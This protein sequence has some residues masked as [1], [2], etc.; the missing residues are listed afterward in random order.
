MFNREIKEIILYNTHTSATEIEFDTNIFIKYAAGAV[1][2]EKRYNQNHFLIN[3]SHKVWFSS[4]LVL[5]F[6]L[7]KKTKPDNNIKN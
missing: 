2:Y 6:I 1:K 3:F 7:I 5:L 4:I